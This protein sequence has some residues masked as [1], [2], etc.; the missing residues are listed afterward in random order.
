[1]ITGL[2]GM[3]GLCNFSCTF[4]V[5]GRGFFCIRYFI[6]F[7]FISRMPCCNVFCIS[8]W[9]LMV[10]SFW[11]KW[12]LLSVRNVCPF[13]SILWN[14]W[15]LLFFVCRPE[16]VSHF[17][18]QLTGSISLYCIIVSSVLFYGGCLSWRF[19]SFPWQ[20]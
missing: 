3:S 2:I 12:K 11:S 8:F 9:Y 17:L 15:L 5:G 10:G 13:W 1:L 20:P 18:L 16:W 4:S 6:F 14:L 7:L 19:V